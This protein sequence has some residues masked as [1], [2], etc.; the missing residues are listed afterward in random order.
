MEQSG[1]SITLAGATADTLAIPKGDAQS[2]IPAVSAWCGA[3]SVV[4]VVEEG[5]VCVAD[6]IEEVLAGD[7]SLVEEKDVVVARLVMMN[8]L[9]VAVQEAC[10]VLKPGMR[11]ALVPSD[12]QLYTDDDEEECEVEEEDT[13]LFS[14][15]PNPFA[16]KGKVVVPVTVRSAMG[17]GCN[18]PSKF[19]TMR[20]GELFG[21]PESSAMA[22]P[23]VGGPRMEPVLRDEYTMRGIRI[24]PTL[25]VSGNTMSS[26]MT[27]TSR[28]SLGSAAVK[29]ALTPLLTDPTSTI[30][31][32]DDL[33]VCLTSLR[34]ME[35]PTEDDWDDEF[36]RA[37]DLTRDSG[38]AQ[39]FTASFGSV[40]NV[41]RLADWVATKWAPAVLKTY[42]IAGIRVG[43]RPVYA[44]RVDDTDEGDAAVEI[45]WQEMKNFETFL[46]GTMR[47]EVGESGIS[48]IRGAG[49][50]KSGFGSVSR[51][52]L[53]GEDILVRRLS[54]AV[55]QAMEKG[56]ATK[57]KPKKRERNVET[58]V[59]KP[60]VSSIV[61]S[62]TVSSAEISTPA[63]ADTETG[64]RSAGT[65]RSAKR[66]R[67]TRMAETGEA[68]PSEPS[69]P[70]SP[71][72]TE[73]TQPES[74]Q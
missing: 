22:S 13:G 24:D 25:S 57:P 41:S 17:G 18:A 73:G 19:A 6:G 36:E 59:E 52:P 7:R 60:V 30:V 62:G 74:W 1:G 3:T 64:P 15:V 55:T 40:P 28:L 10:N 39:L 27:R 71:P 65:R 67:G 14:S 69:T 32:E 16:G 46:V 42:D 2:A 9:K 23:L 56:L 21:L 4:G 53:P 49:D 29:M 5:V 20:Y 43:A 51:K 11:I 66:K 45:Q 48:A 34:G 38:G 33:D 58:I 63:K 37:I 12:M 70:T 54:D 31:L 61:S 44:R 72:A 26:M 8:A 68:K 50:A 47:I 35:L